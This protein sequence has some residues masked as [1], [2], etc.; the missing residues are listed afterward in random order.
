[1]PES[2]KWKE[3]IARETAGMTMEERIAYYRRD[4]SVE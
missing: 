4:S 1:M 3:A 2:G